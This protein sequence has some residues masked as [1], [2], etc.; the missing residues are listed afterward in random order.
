MSGSEDDFYTYASEECKN[1]T[2][3]RIKREDFEIVKRQE[4]QKRRTILD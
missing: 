3:R 1:Q 2:Y 4:V